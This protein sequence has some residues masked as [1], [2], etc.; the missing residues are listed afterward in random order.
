MMK[1]GD[2]VIIPKK[3][4]NVPTSAMKITYETNEDLAEYFDIDIEKVNFKGAFLQDALLALGVSKILFDECDYELINSMKLD[5]HRQEEV[6]AK[7]GQLWVND[8]KATNLD[9]TLQAILVY[10][11]RPLSLI[12]GGDDKGVDLKPLFEELKDL[13]IKVYAIGSN[14]DKLVQLCKDYNIKC[15]GMK[16]L[17]STCR[18]I[19]ESKDIKRVVL[20]SPAASSLD[21]FS[22]YG[23]RGDEFKKFAF[24]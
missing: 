7:N 23:Q 24:L 4:E 5:A 13:D 8:S 15:F 14:E 6:I 20:L 21:Q 22:S 18:N 11:D 9:A 10:K 3:Y 19:K 1:E 17:E 12:L 2:C 16:T